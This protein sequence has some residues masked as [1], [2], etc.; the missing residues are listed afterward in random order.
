[1]DYRADTRGE[2]G[3]GAGLLAGALAL[4]GSVGLGG[5]HAVHNRDID[6]GLLPDV[7]VLQDAAD[8]AAAAGPRPHVLLEPPAVYP[9][10]GRA[11]AV[12]RVADH[13]LEPCAHGG[14]YRGGR[15]GGVGGAEEGVGALLLG[16]LLLDGDGGADWAR[17]GDSAAA[18]EEGGG[19]AGGEGE[20]FGGGR[21]GRARG[22]EDG[23]VRHCGG[24]GGRRWPAGGGLKRE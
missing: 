1:M 20:G 24:G 5:H 8:P 7:A 12:L 15:G 14:A 6:A 9:L 10:D 23:R 17:A 13:L 11:D 18:G 22:G 19:E 16:D 21:E 2:E 4:G 3:D